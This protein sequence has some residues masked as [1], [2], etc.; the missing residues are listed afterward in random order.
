M[1]ERLGLQAP[2]PVT[3]LPITPHGLAS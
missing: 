3:P 1:F 2:A